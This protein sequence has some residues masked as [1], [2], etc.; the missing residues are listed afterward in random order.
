M[1]SRCILNT[2]FPVNCQH[3]GGGFSVCSVCTNDS[4]TKRNVGNRI[5]LKGFESSLCWE[6]SM[7][8][9]ALSV[10]S[11]TLCLTTHISVLWL[12][13]IHREKTM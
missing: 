12:A 11:V 13:K 5:P 8:S 10:T 6:A 2:V 4:T 7:G 1:C 9:W 3:L